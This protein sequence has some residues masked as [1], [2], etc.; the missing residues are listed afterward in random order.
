GGVLYSP[1][2]FFM[3]HPP[4]QYTDEEAYRMTEAYIA[5]DRED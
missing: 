3:K 1:A 5:G 2:A 4:R